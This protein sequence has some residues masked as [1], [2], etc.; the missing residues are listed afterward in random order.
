MVPSRQPAKPYFAY[1]E[2]LFTLSA[3]MWAG[4]WQVAPTPGNQV[5][6]AIELIFFGIVCVGAMCLGAAKAHLQAK[7]FPWLTPVVV[8]Y[9]VAM[10]VFLFFLGGIAIVK[11][12]A[13]L[14]A[15][16]YAFAIHRLTSR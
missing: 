13:I 4:M 9:C 1:A 2:I 10:G 6:R 12:L 15:V 11:L 8:V 3:I 5:A 7:H 16:A 14:I